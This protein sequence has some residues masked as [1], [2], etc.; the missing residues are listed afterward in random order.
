MSAHMR[1][2]TLLR[3]LH[4]G[5]GDAGGFT[6]A[7]NAANEALTN[8]DPIYHAIVSGGSP[9]AAAIWTGEG[10]PEAAQTMQINRLALN[11][12]AIQMDSAA[13]VVLGLTNALVTLKTNLQQ[14]NNRAKSQNFWVEE[15][16]TVVT[17]KNW[18]SDDSASSSEADRIALES[19]IIQ[20][21]QLA[22]AADLS[23]KTSFDML[24]DSEPFI[25]DSAYQPALEQNQNA[26]DQALADRQ[27]IVESAATWQLLDSFLL[28]TVE[29]I[30]NGVDLS[31][32]TDKQRAV[33]L[34]LER[35]LSEAHPMA[36]PTLDLLKGDVDALLM[37]NVMAALEVGATLTPDE[38]IIR[39]LKLPARVSGALGAAIFATEFIMAFVSK[40]DPDAAAKPAVLDGDGNVK[41]HVE[42]QRL[43][44]LAGSYYSPAPGNSE[45]DGAGTV[46]DLAYY[47]RLNGLGPNEDDWGAEAT[48][49]R[50]DLKAWLSENPDSPD[51]AYAE[52]LI[53]ELD[54]AL[55]EAPIGD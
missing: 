28:T 7:R 6:T 35:L 4:P 42:D 13:Q 2:S 40:A 41:A 47:Q 31:A 26:L 50:G 54:V 18:D 52:G 34:L 32:T 55:G 36:G 23:A 37:A 8:Y 19:A 24:S 12:T 17:G 43:A 46:A 48:Q 45:H 5:D 39:L 25:A 10:Q 1:K 38:V 20:T 27:Q 11:V 29:D 21:L 22:T 16:G 53:K 51:A 44:N 14:L 33:G 3:F 49:L 15:D 30:D 9:G